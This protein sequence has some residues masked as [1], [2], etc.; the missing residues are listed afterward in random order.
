MSS[1]PNDTQHPTDPPPLAIT[2]LQRF[3]Q[4]MQVG[5]E[6]WRDGT[7][8]DLTAL[9]AASPEEHA[10]IE[11]L[12]LS[13]AIS[14][15]RDVEGLATLAALGSQNAKSALEVAARQ[16]NPDIQRAIRRHAP[17]LIEDA[18][19]RTAMV[20]ALDKASMSSGWSQALDEAADYHPDEVIA[21]L[22]RGALHGNA[23][24]AVNFSAML[25]YVHGQSEEPFD[26]AQRPFFLKFSTDDRDER[27]DAFRA[28]CEKIGLDAEKYL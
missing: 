21:A 1:S 28:L 14:D 11:T 18:A 17:T 15:W 27:I 3:L 13:R 8:Y 25:M 2:P 24:K 19:Y 4:S 6:Q 9:Q 12:L 10:T 7:G 16:G 23:T 22:L 26:Q 5:L 20:A